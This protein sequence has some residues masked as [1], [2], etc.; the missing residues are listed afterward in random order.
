MSIDCILSFKN[1]A[2]IY[3][4]SHCRKSSVNRCIDDD[5]KIIVAQL[6]RK[7]VPTRILPPLPDFMN[8]S[9]TPLPVGSSPRPSQVASWTRPTEK[10]RPLSEPF[11]CGP[12]IETFPKNDVSQPPSL[13]PP[14]TSRIPLHS[15]LLDLVI[16]PCFFLTILS[17]PGLSSITAPTYIRHFPENEKMSRCHIADITFISDDSQFGKSSCVSLMT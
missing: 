17:R 9:E 12:K 13:S 11:A 1:P 8:L 5:F 14:I 7:S 10:S 16:Q 15:V 3:P 2:F 6:R 4:L